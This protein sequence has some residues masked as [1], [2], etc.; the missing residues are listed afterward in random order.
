MKNNSLLSYLI[1]IC[2]SVSTLKKK[3]HETLFRK[4]DF[5]T[6]PYEA[7]FFKCCAVKNK[8]ISLKRGLE[9][10][11]FSKDSCNW[12]VCSQL[13]DNLPTNEVRNHVA[14]VPRTFGT[15]FNNSVYSAEVPDLLNECFSRHATR[16]C[17]SPSI[18]A[19]RWLRATC[20][21]S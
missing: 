20:L 21:D 2:S 16:I 12:N 11:S 18:C 10:S 19:S 15:M 17:S 3:L 8:Y 6:M 9:A 1:I 7:S 5:Y 13:Y 4:T 14:V